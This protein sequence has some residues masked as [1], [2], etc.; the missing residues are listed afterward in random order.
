V[1]DTA[2]DSP[3]DIL[4]PGQE[5]VYADTSYLAQGRSVVVLIIKA[6]PVQVTDSKQKIVNSAKSVES[7]KSMK[8]VESAKSVESVESVESVKS[9]KSAK[10]VKSV[11]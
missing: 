1:V 8:S 5:L 10:S 4:E 7:A 9:V 3:D 6:A 11:K 2:L